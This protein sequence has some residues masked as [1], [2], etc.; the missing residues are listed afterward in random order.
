MELRELYPKVAV[1]APGVAV[2]NVRESVVESAYEF[3]KRSRA[4]REKFGPI[5]FDQQV[6][7]YRV[8]LP[9]DTILVEP[10]DVWLD[11]RQLMSQTFWNMGLNEIEVR[12]GLHGHELHGEVAV[13]P[14]K[15]LDELPDRLGFEFG[16]AIVYGAIA[17]LLRIPQAEWSDYRRAADYYALFNDMIDQAATRAENGFKVNRTRVVRYG[18]L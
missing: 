3:F 5:P 11:G 7:R 17:R 13:A 1:E 10:T 14:T 16:D 9:M 2:F 18:G 12:E 4:W 15:D 8:Q 6:T